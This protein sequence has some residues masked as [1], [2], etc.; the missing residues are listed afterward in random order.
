MTNLTVDSADKPA[1]HRFYCWTPSALLSVCFGT[2]AMAQKSVSNHN[3]ARHI[4]R[5]L[6]RKSQTRRAPSQPLA[7]FVRG[8][9][10]DEASSTTQITAVKN[11]VASPNVAARD[12]LVGSLW[13]AVFGV[14]V[15]S[16]DETEMVLLKRRNSTTRRNADGTLNIRFI[17]VARPVKILHCVLVWQVLIGMNAKIL[18][19]PC[20]SAV[21]KHSLHLGGN[22]PELPM[23]PTQRAPRASKFTAVLVRDAKACTKVHHLLREGAQGKYGV[24]LNYCTMHGLSLAINGLHR[25]LG[26]LCSLFCACEHNQDR[27]NIQ[28]V[29]ASCVGVCGER[30]RNDPR[31]TTPRRNAAYRSY[32]GSLQVGRPVSWRSG[33]AAWA[34]R[35]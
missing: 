21:I 23:H 22:V 24:L 18:Q 16:H 8:I 29:V 11:T 6:A 7:R 9:A 14:M 15:L 1:N 35:L 2:V 13:R 12:K 28:S 26:V 19:M 25:P 10:A 5:A 33:V 20:V 17:T 4:K 32:S 34:W 30:F 31:Q 3:K 27:H